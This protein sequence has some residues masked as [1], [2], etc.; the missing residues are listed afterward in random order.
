[1][2]RWSRGSIRISRR[3]AKKIVGQAA[4]LPSRDAG[5]DLCIPWLLFACMGTRHTRQA[6]RLPYMSRHHASKHPSISVSS[7]IVVFMVGCQW[8][9]E[10]GWLFVSRSQPGARRHAE[11]DVHAE[12]QRQSYGTKART[13][14]ASPFL[15]NYQPRQCG[16]ATFTTDVCES[17]AS[18]RSRRYPMFCVGHERPGPRVTL[19]LTRV[20]FEIAQ[21]DINAYH[22]AADF[23]NT[24]EVEV[25]CVQ[26]EYGIYGGGLRRAR[27]LHAARGE[28]ARRHHAAHDPH[29]S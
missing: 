17:V 5:F 12:R 13:F 10:L 9:R 28:D 3:E 22:R 8:L 24:N 21:Q 20:R 4:R 23:L 16:L 19:I 18:A 1:M 11:Q 14:I 29:R 2:K 7:A 26:H 27:P 6:G 15:G 25:L